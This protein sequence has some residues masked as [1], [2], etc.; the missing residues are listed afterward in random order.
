MAQVIMD[1]VKG[2]IYSPPSNTIQ[3]LGKLSNLNKGRQTPQWLYTH[4][5]CCYIQREK[6][7]KKGRLKVFILKIVY[8]YEA[9][10]SFPVNWDCFKLYT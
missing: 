9:T 10:L 2:R 7:Q 6:E 5:E 8:F 4:T 3:P 1:D